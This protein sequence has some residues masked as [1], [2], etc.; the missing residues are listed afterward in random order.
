MDNETH[1]SCVDHGISNTVAAAPQTSKTNKP[2]KESQAMKSVSS[3]VDRSAAF[4]FAALV[5]LAA[6]TGCD[7][8][9]SHKAKAQPSTYTGASTAPQEPTTTQQEQSTTT[10]NTVIPLYQESIKVGKREVETGTVRVRKIVKTETVN[11]PVEL[12]HEEV[13][14]DRQPN[15]QAQPGA[16]AFQEQDF[17]IHLSKEEPVVEKTV[18]SSGQIVVQKRSASEQTNLTA[19]VRR[20]DIDVARTG[21]SQNVVIGQNVQASSLPSGASGAA[22]SPGGQTST[23]ESAPITDTATLASSSAGRMVQFSGLKVDQV[24]GDRVFVLTSDGGQ[25]VYAVA[26]EAPAG[27][28]T[29]DTVNLSGTVRPSSGSSS[30]GL[31][32]DAAQ[33]ISSQSIYVEAQKIEPASK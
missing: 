28:K 8:T 32:G 2:K 23:T 15:N 27:I 19:Q 25:K 5:G 9:G 24:I 18:T 7:C 4:T 13:V 11:Q 3:F 21:D 26:S 30:L 12:R 17:T 20:E 10:D 22:E 29:G 6:V 33:T 1:G 16:Q 14:I 31:S